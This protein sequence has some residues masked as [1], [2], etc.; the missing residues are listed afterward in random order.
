LS[1][2]EWRREGVHTELGR[3]SVE[4]WL[5]IDAEHAHKH[6]GQILVAMEGEK[7]LVPDRSRG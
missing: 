4:R 7:G 1:P 5:E 2:D 3:Y 6:A